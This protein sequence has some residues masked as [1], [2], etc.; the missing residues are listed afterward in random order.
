ME[1]NKASQSLRL[2]LNISRL[3]R[4]NL[5]NEYCHPI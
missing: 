2:T 3:C 5:F 4:F 1:E